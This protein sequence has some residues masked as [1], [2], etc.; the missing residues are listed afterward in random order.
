MVKQ[1]NCHSFF[2]KIN[3]SACLDT[4]KHDI[5]EVISEL[6][7]QSWKKKKCKWEQEILKKSE[8][9]KWCSHDWKVS[10]WKKNYFL[11]RGGQKSNF[12]FFFFLVRKLKG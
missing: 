10:I 1:R 9:C 7:L 11:E 4:D 6:I 8:Q 12:I 2:A 5:K 3:P